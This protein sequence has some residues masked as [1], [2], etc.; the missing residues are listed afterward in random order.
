M[1]ASEKKTKK[2]PAPHTVALIVAAGSSTRMGA[3]VSK[4]FLEINRHPV[5]AHTL[6][7]FEAAKTVDQIVVVARTEDITHIASLAAQYHIEKLAAV[8]EGGE[9]RALS[10]QKGFERVHPKAK[11]VA[12]HDG[13]RCLV[14]PEIIDKVVRAAYRHKA[15]TA[16]APVSDTVKTVNAKGFVESTV[17]RKKVFLAATPQVFDTNLYRAALA[18]VENFENMT[19]D[20]QL[21][22]SLPYPVKVVDCG[23]ENIKIT[24]PADLAIAETILRERSKAT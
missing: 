4:Q 20:N 10:V 21:I 2:K 19:D 15:A 9:T 17:D 3:G 23:K 11:F 16:A 8:V 13:A 22:E 5:L 6:R 24:H 12:I 14:T 7:A 18:T 1:A